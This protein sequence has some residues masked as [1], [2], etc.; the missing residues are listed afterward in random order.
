LQ[1]KGKE[2]Y[3]IPGAPPDLARLGEGCAF[4]PRCAYVQDACRSG[5]LALKG[6]AENHESACRRVQEGEIELNAA[7][8]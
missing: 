6:V 8:A 2:L 3:T 4:A 5:E 1:T 7:P